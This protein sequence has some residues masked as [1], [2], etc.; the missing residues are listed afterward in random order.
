MDMQQFFSSLADVP[1]L[2]TTLDLVGIFFF[3]ISGALLAA[4]KRFDFIGSVVLSLLA[5]LGG[6]FMRDVLL[7]RGL[8]D[9][10]RHPVYLAPPV[11][12]SVLVYAT[13]IRPHRLKLTILA[14]DAAGLALFT[15]AGVVIA[16]AQGI[17]PV[18]TVVIACIGA[19]AGG[20]LRDVVANEEPVL[21]DPRGV[22]A[23][24][25]LLGATA[26]TIAAENGA[27]NATTGTL[28][29]LAVFGVRMMGHLRGWRLPSSEVT[30]DKE[31]LRRLRDLALQAAPQRRVL[32]A[33]RGGAAA[34]GATAGGTGVLAGPDGLADV[35]GGD[36]A[37]SLAGLAEADAG[38]V[39][40]PRTEPVTVVD[41]ATQQSVRVDPETGI[42]DI[43]DLRTGLT[44]SYE[45][46]DADGRG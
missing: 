22:Y 34:A 26:A 29:A 9:S 12:A 30:H 13:V 5:G 25:C 42:I 1:W 35:V 21:F 24:P 40:G 4:G 14:F 45:D 10:L 2:L 8:P 6:G 36:D 18:A 31:S 23:V 32:R 17:P 11:L 33:R 44:R 46:P 16:H 7:D 38:I 27:L 37:G 28:I 39:T 15:V 43:T 20:V 19:L 41:T 3:A